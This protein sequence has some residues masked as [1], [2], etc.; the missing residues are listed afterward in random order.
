MATSKMP[1]NWN[2]F[3][4]EHRSNASNAS[5]STDE[6][7]ALTGDATLED[8]A[9]ACLDGNIDENTF[10]RISSGIVIS[11]AQNGVGYRGKL[12]VNKAKSFS[13]EYINHGD[14]GIPEDQRKGDSIVRRAFNSD[15]IDAARSDDGF[16]F[17]FS[18]VRNV[19]NDW[20]GQVFTEMTSDTS[21]SYL[22]LGD[23]DLADVIQYM[24]KNSY[25]GKFSR[26]DELFRDTGISIVSI[27]E[28]EFGK[29]RRDPAFKSSGVITNDRMCR[30]R[31][32]IDGQ[33]SAIDFK[34]NDYIINSNTGEHI[35]IS[36]TAGVIISNNKNAVGKYDLADEA[37][38]P[39]N[40][41]AKN[42]GKSKYSSRNSIF[43]NNVPIENIG[44]PPAGYTSPL[45]LRTVKIP[46]SN[47]ELKQMAIKAVND[48]DTYGHLN[49]MGLSEKFRVTAFAVDVTSER[50]INPNHSET[51]RNI[52][53]SQDSDSKY[54]NSKIKVIVQD[55]VD[56]SLHY[57]HTDISPSELIAACSQTGVASIKS[58]ERR[59]F[60]KRSE[61]TDEDVKKLDA[62]DKK[63]FLNNVD[64]SNIRPGRTPE[65][66]NVV[67][68]IPQ[69]PN[70]FCHRFGLRNNTDIILST[71]VRAGQV[72]DGKDGKTS[73]IVL[74]NS[75]ED[76][77]AK[78][79]RLTAYTPNV[80]GNRKYFNADFT[81][82]EVANLYYDQ[83]GGSFEF[84][85]QG[86]EQ[87][88]APDVTD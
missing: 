81:V 27:T 58:I 39:V 19:S 50:V 80:M 12:Y 71:S 56:K 10:V 15:Y 3:I 2:G 24:A 42:A 55:R 75:R 57:C 59:D 22:L 1:D 6:Y 78:S 54:S 79:I 13:V 7:Y 43:L 23:T 53:L 44:K 45:D 17:D 62:F 37:A 66:R 34:L 5:Y 70:D 68:D 35:D 14:G 48:A 38:K 47:D 49:E 63:R 88:D 82:S 46:L 69:L 8:A 65:F 32:S 40:Q 31:H 67:L 20:N 41:S 26:T 16:H 30:I 33:E 52:I 28:R 86:E 74:C 4:V 29:Y 73:N 72:I 84:G 60:I 25:Y 85:H 64:N 77:D 21:N 87:P 18:D 76:P 83:G 11:D 9:A 61:M 36:P 51:S